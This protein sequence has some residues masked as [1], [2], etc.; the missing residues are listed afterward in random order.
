MLDVG[1][2]FMN[3]AVL[4]LK[5]KF[6]LLEEMTVVGIVGIFAT[7]AYPILEGYLQRSKQNEAK[8]SLRAVYTAQKVYSATIKTYGVHLANSILNWKKVKAPVMRSL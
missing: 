5:K 8:L 4:C 1:T 2:I 3:S 6:S 7:L